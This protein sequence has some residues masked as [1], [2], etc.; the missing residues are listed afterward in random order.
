MQLYGTWVT[1]GLQITAVAG[2]RVHALDGQDLGS[3]TV[4]PE[5]ECG[6][7]ANPWILSHHTRLKMAQLL[8]RIMAHYLILGRRI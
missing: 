4:L 3:V 1:R 8:R 6:R 2:D 7:A 5:L